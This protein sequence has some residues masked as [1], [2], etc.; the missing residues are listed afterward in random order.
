MNATSAV[1]RVSVLM[2]IYNAAAFLERTLRSL[3]A[4][5]FRDFELV[6]VE[7]G[8]TD[9]SRALLERCGDAR[10]RL[11]PLPQN[12]GRTP[13]L[14]HAFDQARG[15]LIAV[16]DADDLNR[17][18][19]LEREVRFLDAHPDVVLVGTWAE[20]ID[21]ED[22][23]VGQYQP[24]PSHDALVDT[25]GVE[26]P[27]V[28]SSAMYRAA[29]ARAVGG[30]PAQ[31]TH[32]QDLGLWLQLLGRGRVAVLP[33]PLCQFRIAAGGMT[34]G[35]RHR[36]DAARDQLDLLAR[37]RATLPLSAA[38]RARNREALAIAR[39]RYAWALAQN[40][41]PLRALGQATRA[42][43]SDPVALASNRVTR[44]FLGR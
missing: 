1:P 24:P 22:R 34:Q 25:F 29:D 43:F 17:P 14:R 19:R 21:M 2:T 30:Y 32:S 10:V 15:A 41:S 8:S 42:L 35:R 9:G 37:I 4:Q 18:D 7:N 33:E 40:G 36:T 11:L 31:Y 23:V 27:I 13:A 16:L 20:F 39:A 12:I 44:G 38:G 5:T 6:A 26:N 3:F 28:H